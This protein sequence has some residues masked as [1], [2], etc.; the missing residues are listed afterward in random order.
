MRRYPHWLTKSFSPDGTAREVRA[1]VGELSLTTVC[2]SA[3]CPNLRECYS[4]RQLT[5]MILGSRCTRACRFCAVEHGRPVPVE[6]DEPWRLAEAVARLRLKHVVVTS[7]ARDDLADEGAGQFARVIDAVR[8]RN[9]ATTVEVLVPDFHGR[10]ELIGEVM[11]RRPEVFAHNLETVER[12]SPL[13]RHQAQ[14]RRSLAVL[15]QGAH[16]AQTTLIKSALM[17]GMGEDV[18]EVRAAFDDLR[19]AGCTHLTLGQYLRPS[20]A[21]LPV[22]EYLSGER[23]AMYQQLAYGAGFQWV[24]AGSFVRSSYHAIDAMSPESVVRSR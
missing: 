17:L 18:D 12:L 3:L 7:V 1:L 19:A 15:A 10:A 8:A 20:A 5:F 16:L 22:M 9:P 14:Y 11:G 21:H 4:Q 24:L 13:V 6:D 23:F 2:E